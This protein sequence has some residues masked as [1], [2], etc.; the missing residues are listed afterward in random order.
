MPALAQTAPSAAE[1]D[2]R[3]RSELPESVRSMLPAF[4][5]GGYLPSEMSMPTG[6]AGG[7]PDADQP[8]EA[9]GLSAR[10]EL[11]SELFLEGDVRMRQGRFTVTG[12]EARYDQVAGTVADFQRNLV[13][14]ATTARDHA[15]LALRQWQSWQQPS[16]ANWVLVTNDA[17][18]C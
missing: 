16:Y 13:E 11:D 3:P 4:C 8:V 15:R 6:V 18:S 9:S 5:D 17:A 10:Y 14:I 7:P 2:W 12:S 1:I